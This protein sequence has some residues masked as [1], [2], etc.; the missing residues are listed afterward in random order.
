MLGNVKD[1]DIF[2]KYEKL[3]KMNTQSALLTSHLATKYL[4]EQGLFVLTGAAAAFSGPT[5]Y[6]FAY[7]ITKSATHA[8]ALQMAERTELPK[9]SSV[10][11]ILP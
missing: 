2:E 8:L 5:N 4:A 10:I 11:C 1:N 9:T 6:A 3:D 7:G